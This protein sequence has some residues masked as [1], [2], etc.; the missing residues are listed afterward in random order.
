MKPPRNCTFAEADWMALASCWLPIAYADEVG[1]KPVAA[2]LLDLPLVVYRTPEGVHVAKDLCIHRGAALSLGRVE[3]GELVCA[4]HGFRFG[5]GGRCTKIPATPEAPI[6]PKLCLQMFP[7]VERMGIIWTCLSGEPKQPLPEWPE[8][9]DASFRYLHLPPQVWNAS[10]ARAIENF[11][12]VAH[13]SWIHTGTF[14]NAD[15]H[16]VPKYEVVPT[17]AGFHTEYPYLAQNPAYSPLPDEKYIRRWMVYDLTL[18]Y[19]CR[20]AINYDGGRRYCIFNACAPVSARRV[21]IFFAVAMNFD[22]D[23]PAEEILGWE[24]KVLAE[25]KPVV[26]SQRPEELPLDLS[27]EFHLRFDRMST[28]YRQGLV[29]LG[30]Q[31]ERPAQ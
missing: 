8:T 17:P 30:L 23:K 6:S 24:R 4:Y 7:A 22:H 5:A 10:A 19:S 20:L 3:A 1:D 14:G 28:L 29:K 31:S 18:P 12:D 2:E 15:L 26:E 21:K 11:L 25:D 27:E 9:E 13:F 16:E